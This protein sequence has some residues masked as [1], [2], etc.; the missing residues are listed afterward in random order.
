M[1]KGQI[2]NKPSPAIVFDI[3]GILIEQ[4]DTGFFDR[5][6]SKMPD[7]VSKPFDKVK[8]LNEIRKYELIEQSADFIQK[9]F[10]MDYRIILFAHRNQVYYEELVDYFEENHVLFNEIIVGGQKERERILSQDHVH[11]YYY[12][13]PFHYSTS[14]KEKERHIDSWQELTV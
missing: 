1:E 4:L 13:H 5:L 10:F 11:Y 9:L 3:D 12:S 6:H 14:N 8:M 7:I 2:S